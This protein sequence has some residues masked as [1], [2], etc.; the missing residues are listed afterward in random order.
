MRR[1]LGALV[2]LFF[3]CAT[4]APASAAYTITYDPGGV[5]GTFMEKYNAIDQAGGR[6]VID[7]PCISACTLV[8]GLIAPDRVCAT[9]R[10]RLAFHS[11]TGEDHKFSPE[12]TELLW[13]Q[14]PTKAQRML[15]QRGWNGSSPHPELIWL[16]NKAVLSL[17]KACPTRND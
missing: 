14:Y 6:V 12:G 1:L 17:V 8:V 15:R 10:A 11:A 16:D 2:G 4:A 7:G 5:I 3:I 13:Q 9:P